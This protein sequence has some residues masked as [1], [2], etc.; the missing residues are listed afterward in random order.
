MHHVLNYLLRGT[1]FL[2]LVI[3][4]HLSTRRSSLLPFEDTGISL[5]YIGWHLSNNQTRCVLIR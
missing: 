4:N 5:T 3:L 2:F 1:Y